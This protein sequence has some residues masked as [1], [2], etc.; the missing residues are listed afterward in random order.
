MNMGNGSYAQNGS[1]AMNGSYQVTSHSYGY[2]YP[3]QN[4]MTVSSGYGY[5]IQNPMATGRGYEYPIQNS[6]DPGYAQ[7]SLPPLFL[8]PSDLIGW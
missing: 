8:V 4:S 7:V 5:P 2:A 6:M 1:Y 3:M